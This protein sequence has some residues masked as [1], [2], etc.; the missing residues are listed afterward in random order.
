M[1][2][3]KQFEALLRKMPV[4]DLKR[5]HAKAQSDYEDARKM[6]Y[7]A[8]EAVLYFDVAQINDEITRRTHAKS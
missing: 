2:L 5:T 3:R 1:N 4:D 7:C 6:G 8:L